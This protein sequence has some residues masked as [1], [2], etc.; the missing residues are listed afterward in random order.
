[1]ATPNSNKAMKRTYQLEQYALEFMHKV[2]W[3]VPQ[4]YYKGVLI[5]LLINDSNNK[6]HSVAMDTLVLHIPSQN[7]PKESRLL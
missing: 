5:N 7:S 6:M 2:S 4:K 3:M 1:M